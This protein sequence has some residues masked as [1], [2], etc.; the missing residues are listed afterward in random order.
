MDSERHG[1]QWAFAYHECDNFQGSFSTKQDAIAEALAGADDNST[2][3]VG[4]MV[5][6]NQPEE[7][8]H[9]EDWIE[10]VSCQDDYCGDWAEDWDG[11]TDS[12]RHELEREVRAVM[13]A[14]LDRHKL[15]P[16]HFMVRDVEDFDVVDGQ[17]VKRER[18][19][20]GGGG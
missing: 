2:I 19:T 10:H 4:R 12:Q 11:S 17:A 14:W 13:A 7:L 5:P 18:Q 8:W 16:R 9:A 15:R 6:P 1:E 20:A 3:C